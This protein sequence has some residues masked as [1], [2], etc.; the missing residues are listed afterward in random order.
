MSDM[1][2]KGLTLAAAVA[3]AVALTGAT[4]TT[5]SAADK[6]KCYGIAKA[7]ENHCA[8]AAG[9]HSCAGQSTV[10]Y[11]GGEWKSVAAGTCAEMGGS[12][13]PFEGTNDKK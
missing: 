8:N 12:T 6:E 13:T 11:D 9:T 1:K 5:A 2:I 7:G 10:D 3:G 4:T